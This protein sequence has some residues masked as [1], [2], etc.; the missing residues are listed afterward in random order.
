MITELEL[1]GEGCWYLLV[2]IDYFSKWI[3]V[4][5]LRIKLSEEISD[6]FD[7]HFL[8][9]YG[10][11]HCI[12]IDAGKEFEG[13]SM[14]V[15]NA[16]GVAMWKASSGYACSKGLVKHFNHEIKID[17]CKYMGMKPGSYG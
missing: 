1:K 9:Q 12:R 15:C 6:Q 2:T 16:S 14:P 10:K 11:L 4:L 13:V 17:I 7:P 8:P 3:V 5:S